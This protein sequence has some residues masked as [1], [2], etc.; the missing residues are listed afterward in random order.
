[1]GAITRLIQRTR[2]KAKQLDTV[3]LSTSSTRVF[4]DIAVDNQPAGRV[5]FKVNYFM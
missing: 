2:T 3:A 1:M 4:F 5:V